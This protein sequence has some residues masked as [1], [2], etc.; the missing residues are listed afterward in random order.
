MAYPRDGHSAASSPPQPSHT[1]TLPSHLHDLSRSDSN[2]S[3]VTIPSPS[4][5]PVEVDLSRRRYAANNDGDGGREGA[6]IEVSTLPLLRRNRESSSSSSDNK[7]YSPH[8]APFTLSATQA[9]FPT[10]SRTR[11]LAYCFGVVCVAWYFVVAP[12]MREHMASTPP[13]LSGIFSSLSSAHSDLDKRLAIDFPAHGESSDSIVHVISSTKLTG[14]IGGVGQGSRSLAPATHT[15]H[16]SRQ[17]C[18]GCAFSFTRPPARSATSSFFITGVPNHGAGVGHQFIEWITGVI[19][20][21][22]LNLTYIYTPLLK[23]S[24]RWNAFLGLSEGEDTVEDLYN[25]YGG[26]GEVHRREYPPNIDH[27]DATAWVRGTMEEVRARTDVRRLPIDESKLTP[28]QRA[29]TPGLP[30]P[31]LFELKW[32]AIPN[33]L[34]ACEPDIYRTIRRKYCAA[35]IRHPVR[36]DLYAE[37][38]AKGKL[39]ITW[40]LRCGDSCFDAYRTTSFASILYTTTKLHALYRKLEPT[41]EL[42][43]HFFSQDPHNGTA[44]DHF[45]PLLESL[46]PLGMPM[47]THWKTKSAQVLHHLITSDVLFGALSGFSWLAFLHH[48]GVAVGSIPSCSEAIT[49]D[50]Y[51]GEFDEKEFTASWRKYK[52]TRPKYETW[53]DCLDMQ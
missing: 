10:V 21:R 18:S 40:H 49:Y 11:W 33:H 29:L 28:P 30:L 16:P 27:Y 2:S 4:P 6:T 46:R 23:Q 53:Q 25:T 13:A 5:S 26:V 31:I 3:S 50:K 48:N 35:R 7:P 52:N 32:L 12:Y 17:G 19:V 24:S 15:V 38:R 39:I 9:A 36:T 42:A 47:R 45:A 41:R 34:Y 37:D 22:N 1:Y 44:T 51:S 14:G 20:A 8:S 43:L